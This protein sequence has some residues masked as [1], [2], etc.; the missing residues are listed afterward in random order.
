MAHA[1]THKH[2]PG[3]YVYVTTSGT[4]VRRIRIGKIIVYK[5]GIRYTEDGYPA[6]YV[7]AEL[8]ANPQEAFDAFDQI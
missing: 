1:T 5:D 8:F 6:E 3:E 7:E 4:S 2:L